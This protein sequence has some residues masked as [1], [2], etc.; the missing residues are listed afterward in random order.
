MIQAGIERADKNLETLILTMDCN[1]RW[2]LEA[3]ALHV[4]YHG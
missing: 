2:K 4:R 1:G 3:F